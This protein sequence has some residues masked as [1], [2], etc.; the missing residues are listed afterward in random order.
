MKKPL[1][2]PI[3]VRPLPGMFIFQNVTPSLLTDLPA[4][5]QKIISLLPALKT[6]KIIQFPAAVIVDP[7]ALNVP[8]LRVV[9]PITVM[10]DVLALKVPPLMTT[11]LENVICAEL[12]LEGAS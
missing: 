12:A 5:T 2:A 8:A 11:E 4:S 1:L 9:S 6:F 3:P 10:E 7:P